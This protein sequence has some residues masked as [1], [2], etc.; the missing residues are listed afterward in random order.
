MSVV[1]DSKIVEESTLKVYESDTSQDHDLDNFITNKVVSGLFKI[2]STFLVMLLVLMSITIVYQVLSRY[3]LGSPSSLSEEVL[4]YA[5]IW[6][7]ILGAGVACLHGRHLN[8]PLINNYISLNN[9]R[10]LSAFNTTVTI[11][12]GFIM[13]IGGIVAVNKNSNFET[14]MLGVSIGV[15]QSVIFIA[16][17]LII[18]NEIVFFLNKHGLNKNTLVALVKSTIF[19]FIMSM[20]WLWFRTT[21]TYEYLTFE[22]LELF[23]T[24]ILFVSFFFFLTVGTPIA[25]GLAF[26]GMI[27]LSLFIESADL[28]AT[29]GEKIFGSLDNFGFLALPFFILAGN[30]MN[31]GGIAQRLINLAMLLGKRIPGTLW[32]ANILGNILF[33]SISGSS[34]AAATAIGGI[35]S[36]MAKKQKYDRGITAALNATSSTSG[37]MIPPTGIFILYSLLIGGSASIA[38][39][40]VA[41]YIPGLM[42]AGSAMIMAYV[43]ARRLNYKPDK[44]PVSFSLYLKTF[45]DALP[46]LS[47]VIIIMAGIIG[48]IFTAVEASGIAVLYSFILAL[49]YKTLTWKKCFDILFNT[50]MTAA[51]IFFLI[52]CSGLMSWSMTFASIPETIADFLIGFSDNTNVVL[53]MMVVI[54]VVVGVFMDMTP[55]ILIFTP[56]FYPIAHS[57]GIDPIHF[58]IIIVY[59]LSIGLVTPPVGPVLF[60]SCSINETT[61]SEV[62]KP[63]LPI[64]ALQ[65]IGAFFIVFIPE[66]SLYLPKLF[67]IIQ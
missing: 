66:I 30:I 25:L 59:T 5:L 26:S 11:I 37:M 20:G 62:I 65:I 57:M 48:G 53:A 49:C 63:I 3:V 32:Q 14:P 67:G 55:A 21:T 12:Y 28:V 4:R 24:V 13:L 35:V 44:S 60:V 22:K 47:L 10:M 52:A 16:G 43:Y 51:V 50:A 42:L 38:G 31:Q 1:T 40:F 17:F 9:Q 36:P 6:L 46:A 39:L 33:G 41:G 15:F 45:A 7:G 29:V 27:T 18:V 19:I 8:L 56:I 61:I 23:S 54:L 64:F 34:L 2:T 58:G